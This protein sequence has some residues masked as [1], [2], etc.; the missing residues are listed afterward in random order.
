MWLLFLNTM[1]VAFPPYCF[2]HIVDKIVISLLWLL[3]WKLERDIDTRDRIV[4]I[5]DRDYRKY[6]RWLTESYVEAMSELEEAN[7]E[8][9]REQGNRFRD[10][11]CMTCCNIHEKVCL[12]MD[13]ECK[14]HAK[15]MKI[16]NEETEETE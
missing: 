9:I 10:A 13:G 6:Y 11:Y 14:Q 12:D 7:L 3:V 16:L 2:N 1:F 4:P 8:T 5:R 15:L